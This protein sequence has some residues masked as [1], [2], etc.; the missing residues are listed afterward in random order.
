[1]NASDR[2]TQTDRQ[3]ARDRG[4]ILFLFLFVFVLLFLAVRWG[5][6]GR[7]RLVAHAA[8]RH[9][10]SRT[11]CKLRKRYALACI[12]LQAGHYQ[13]RCWAAAAAAE[14]EKERAT[15]AACMYERTLPPCQK[16]QKEKQLEMLQ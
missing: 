4:S 16:G 3:T 15:T 12:C 7:V 5:V 8:S 11:P 9:A 1:M 14:A 2:Q 6:G 10:R 13:R